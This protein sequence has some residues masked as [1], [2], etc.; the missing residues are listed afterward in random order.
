LQQTTS[1]AD[2]ERADEEL[3]EYEEPKDSQQ[4]EDDGSLYQP[5]LLVR[6][7][8]KNSAERMISSRKI[9]TAPSVIA[10]S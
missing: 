4:S 6:D 7:S 3:D 9:E 1:Q 2:F 8:R 5:T 10:K